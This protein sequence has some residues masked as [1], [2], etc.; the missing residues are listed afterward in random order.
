MYKWMRDC[1]LPISSILRR[2][3]CKSNT[4]IWPVPMNDV[5]QRLDELHQEME[6]MVSDN[7][8]LSFINILNDVRDQ[9]IISEFIKNNANVKHTL[10]SKLSEEI[11][12]NMAQDID[13]EIYDISSLD[14]F[15]YLNAT[16]QKLML[17]IL[18]KAISRGMIRCIDSM[19]KTDKFR[20]IAINI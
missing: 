19:L 13:N 1:Q 11:F 10:R 9:I 7:S 5:C 16:E 14:A 3:Q 6:T 8:D 4:D 20:H 2:I 18:R 12:L 15:K 17:S